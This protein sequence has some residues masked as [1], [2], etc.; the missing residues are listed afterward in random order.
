MVSPSSRSEATVHPEA[1]DFYHATLQWLLEQNIL[2]RE[3]SLLVA[4][5]A[6]LDH[7]VLSQLHFRTATIS[8]LDAD[9]APDTMHRSVT[10]CRM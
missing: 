9:L 1:A 3:M 5:G 7:F 10:S 6:E 8:N 2:T 4:C